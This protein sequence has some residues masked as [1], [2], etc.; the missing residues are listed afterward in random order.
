MQISWLHR[1]NPSLARLRVG[2]EHAIVNV[3]L[4]LGVIEGVQE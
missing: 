3:I 4:N 2:H 1:L